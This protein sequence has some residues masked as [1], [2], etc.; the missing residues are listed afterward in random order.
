MGVNGI[1]DRLGE[2]RLMGIVYWV[3]MRGWWERDLSSADICQRCT[4]ASN[5]TLSIKKI[6]GKL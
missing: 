3:I 5:R 4:K 2:R 1:V 6:A